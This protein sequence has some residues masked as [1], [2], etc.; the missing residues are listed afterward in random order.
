MTI[1]IILLIAIFLFGL[2]LHVSPKSKNLKILFLF[3]SF[4]SCT[5][6]LGLRAYDVGTDTP[7]YITI[8]KFTNSIPLSEILT[9]TSI[10]VPYFIDYTASAS[11]ES[12]FLLWCKFIHLFSNNPQVFLFLTA[13]LTCFLAAKFIYDNCIEDVFFPTIV[14][15]CESMFINSL[16][17]VRQMLA[18]AIA[19]QAYKYL[20]KKEIWRSLLIILV[21]YMVHNTAAVTLII[22]LIMLLTFKE[23]RKGF[24]GIAVIICLLPI[25]SIGGQNIISN[26]FPV[27]APYYVSKTSQNFLGAGTILMITIEILGI[28]YMYHK[29]FVIDNSDKVSL[30]VLASIMFEI[31]GFKMIVFLRISLYFR[32]YLM[33]FFEQLIEYIK[34]QYRPFVKYG[35]LC[36]LVLFYI[37][38]ASS[39]AIKYSFFN[40]IVTH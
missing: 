21:A 33:I 37:S 3:L 25:I 35:L 28:I 15:L 30:I 19:L 12:G 9:N 16:N 24:S 2:I 22:A 29:R 1:Y 38:Y 27:Y 8:F 26:V 10:R 36:I 32:A 18:C 34:P 5:L 6:I 39:G 20:R 11:V 13:G 7:S 40:S 14:F 31:I 17:L 4:F 23:K